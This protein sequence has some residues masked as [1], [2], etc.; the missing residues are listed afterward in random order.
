MKIGQGARHKRRSLRDP[1]SQLSHYLDIAKSVA[2]RNSSLPMNFDTNKLRDS[3]YDSGEILSCPNG[4]VGV[5]TFFFTGRRN[6][7]AE[8]DAEEDVLKLYWWLRYLVCR[9]FTMN[10]RLPVEYI[11]CS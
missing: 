11:L 8:C 7:R 6:G 3:G 4:V 10:L 9:S 5:A 1:V 2:K